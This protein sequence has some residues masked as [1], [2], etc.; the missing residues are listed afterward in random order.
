MLTMLAPLLSLFGGT[1]FRLFI[2]NL[3]E[4]VKQL[5]DHKQELERMSL[6]DRLDQNLH[7]RT[8]EALKAQ[9]EMGIKVVEAQSA[10]AADTADSQGFLE[11]IKGINASTANFVATGKWWID[12]WPDLIGSWNSAIRPTMAV[13]AI[14]LW[15]MAV[16]KAGWVM[17]DWDK[18]LAGGIMGLFIGD[19]IHATRNR[20]VS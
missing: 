13:V 14:A 11:T 16:N 17:T 1:A 20:D 10:A 3:F 9:Q 4:G 19:R 7:T 15:I 6:Q 2:G 18:D 8:I 5:M 12:M